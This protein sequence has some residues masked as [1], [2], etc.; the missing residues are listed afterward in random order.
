MDLTSLSTE[1]ILACLFVALVL[2]F[3]L[4][5]LFT[6]ATNIER[7]VVVGGL[8]ILTSLVAAAFLVIDYRSGHRSGVGALVSACLV[9]LM[10]YFVG[11]AID[12]LLGPV[13]VSDESRQGTLGAD[14]AD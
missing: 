13:A 9:A 10:G 8:T 7:N 3:G 1:F 12:W 11:R 4:F 14:L 6:R 2:L 5:S